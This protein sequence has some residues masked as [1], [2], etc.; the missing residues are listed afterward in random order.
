M[1]AKEVAIFSPC[2][3]TKQAQMYNPAD[4]G[5]ARTGM[6]IYGRHA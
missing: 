2:G 6:E 4:I 3:F 5:R 1:E